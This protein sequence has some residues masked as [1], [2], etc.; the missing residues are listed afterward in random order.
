[1]FKELA[2]EGNDYNHDKLHLRNC[3][4][5]EKKNGHAHI[6]ASLTRTSEIIPIIDGVLQ[7]GKWQSILFWEF[8][9][10]RER[11]IILQITGE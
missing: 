2:P 6:R 1:K 8:D 9:G 4:P 11:T 10:P 5:E 3:P 7:L